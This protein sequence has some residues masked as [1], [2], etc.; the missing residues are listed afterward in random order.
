[1]QRRMDY[2]TRTQL[3]MAATNYDRLRA[4]Q[5][6]SVVPEGLDLNFLSLPVE[7]IFYRQL[8]H[9]EFDVSELSLSSYV[10]TLEQDD[11]PFIAIPVF[12]SRYFRHQSIFVNARSNIRTASD[13]VGKRVGVPEYQMTAAVWQ[14]GFL[15]DDFG[16]KFQDMHYFTGG[17]EAPGRSE[18]VPFA[19][20]PGV[21]I[22]PIGPDETL[23]E[24][25]A[26][27]DLDATISASVPPSFGV[28]PD[29]V[30]LFPDYKT[31]E[32]EYFARTQIF[33]IM[34]VIVIRREVLDE[35]PWIAR[36]LM[37][38]F[39]QAL[40]IAEEDLRYRSSLK[41]MLPW[42]ADHVDETIAALGD[43]Y[44]SYGL[45]ENRHVLQTFLEYS[46]KQGLAQRL[47]KPEDIFTP[48]ALGSFVI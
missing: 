6:G 21:T 37:K 41:V 31:V 14:R 11:P 35:H 1:M 47:W 43:N 32:K 29:V 39:G 36:S 30:R 2:M 26:A 20:P 44:F 19:A 22:T 27:G 42:L 48:H 10:L 3:T 17:M 13:L 7:E 28:S 34:H 46:H 8:K 40:E 25:L 24:M 12:P 9:H 16:V 45:E 5:D 18:K 23:S 33:P 4:L 38:A 15:E